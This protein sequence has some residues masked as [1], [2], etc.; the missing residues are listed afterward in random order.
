MPRYRIPQGTGGVQDDLPELLHGLGM[1][2]RKVRTI[3]NCCAV[4]YFA[5]TVIYYDSIHTEIF[6][7]S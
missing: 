2:E 7:S 4:L 6:F 1:W 5:V 3:I